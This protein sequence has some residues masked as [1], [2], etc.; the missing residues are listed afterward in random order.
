[1]NSEQ[2]NHSLISGT[3]SA[4]GIFLLSVF[5][6]GT[7]SPLLMAPFGASCVL[8][9]AVPESPLSQPKNVIGGH[10]ISALVG[11]V[12]VTMLPVSPLVLSLSVAVAIILMVVFKVIHP[13]AGADPIV[14]LM[15]AKGFSFLL[16]PVVSGSILLVLIAYFFHR[17]TAQHTYPKAIS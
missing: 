6:I 16:F 11:V 1:M 2:L 3:G 8:L 17:I 15:G 10:F 13:P 9:F 4:I 5:T 7:G 12:F 14:I